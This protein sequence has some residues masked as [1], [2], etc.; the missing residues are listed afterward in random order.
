MGANVYNDHQV[1]KLKVAYIS[2]AVDGDR[3]PIDQNVGYSTAKTLSDIG[4]DDFVTQRMLTSV[5]PPSPAQSATAIDTSAGEQTIPYTGSNAF[6][7]VL[8]SLP[9]GEPYPAGYRYDSVNSQ[10]IVSPGIS[11][12]DG[13]VAY[14]S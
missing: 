14:V 2:P 10:V 6:P 13:V 12:S 3:L 7:I 4:D 1:A 8:F 5:V 11:A 9:S